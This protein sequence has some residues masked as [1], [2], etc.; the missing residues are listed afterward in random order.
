MLDVL[1]A[2][3]VL[4][5]AWSAYS[6]DQYSYINASIALK[7]AAG[8]LSPLDLQRINTWL[9]ENRQ[10]FTT[11]QYAAGGTNIQRSSLAGAGGT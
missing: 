6:T 3:Q 5:T 7:Q 4:Y 10:P 2:Q 9:T 1:N 8:T 11:T